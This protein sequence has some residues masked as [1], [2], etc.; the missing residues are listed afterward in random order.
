MAA[1]LRLVPPPVEV[2]VHARRLTRGAVADVACD[3]RATPGSFGGTE[4]RVAV[5]DPLLAYLALDFPMPP[6][7][8]PRPRPLY[9]GRLAPVPTPARGVAGDLAAALREI[10]DRRSRAARAGRSKP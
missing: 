9:V 2:V 1:P 5:E 10:P 3:E 4:E 7:G 8:E 6:R